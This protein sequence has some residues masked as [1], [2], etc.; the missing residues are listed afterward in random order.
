[1]S[2]VE[3][4][5]SDAEDVVGPAGSHGAPKCATKQRIDW[6][7]TISKTAAK[8]EIRA[9]VEMVDS[10]ATTK[11]RALVQTMLTHIKNSKNPEVLEHAFT[12][13]TAMLDTHGMLPPPRCIAPNKM[14]TIQLAWSSGGA[15]A[16]SYMVMEKLSICLFDQQYGPPSGA[17]RA[18]KLQSKRDA[19][20][21]EQRSRRGGRQRKLSAVASQAAAAAA[22]RKA[23][24]REKRLAKAGL[25]GAFK[26]SSE[27]PIVTLETFWT[28]Q[29][30]GKY[31]T[32]LRTMYARQKSL[33]ARTGG[34]NA[35]PASSDTQLPTELVSAASV[36]HWFFL[37]ENSE[38]ASKQPVAA[39]KIS[40]KRK[41]RESKKTGTKTRIS[42]MS[43][44]A[45][46]RPKK[47]QKTRK[48]SA[49]TRQKRK[50][51]K[52]LAK[53]KAKAEAKAKKAKVKEAK[54]AKKAMARKARKA[55][56]AKAKEAKMARKAKKKVT[57]SKNLLNKS[58]VEK[59]TTLSNRAKSRIKGQAKLDA[60]E[61]HRQEIEAANR[62]FELSRKLE[63]DNLEAE[64]SK[65][66][67]QRAANAQAIV[68]EFGPAI[69]V[70]MEEVVALVDYY[71]IHSSRIDF[72]CEWKQKR[73]N[74]K[75]AKKSEKG[76]AAA[77]AAVSS[78][79]VVAAPKTSL[80]RWEKLLMS[81]ERNAR[82]LPIQ[83]ADLFSQRVV[84]FIRD[85]WV[86]VEKK[87][88]RGRKK[89]K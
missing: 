56:K 46:R 47:R 80:M 59:P 52:K 16:I 22:K 74:P 70:L 31:G 79:S 19:A 57:K 66:K 42:K 88:W 54:K 14:S 27:M 38:I 78:V 61:T 76:E 3:D 83:N 24:A 84:Q 40:Q 28:Q 53:A 72:E 5:D 45:S 9:D 48:E 39:L 89:R 51:E 21:A 29:V 37:D 33:F 10:E 17:K 68:K 77:G 32:L 35:K 82:S 4:D 34:G 13:L 86:R 60:A 2:D 25:Q 50:L 73:G 58:K 49:S 20:K 62:A 55:E 41:K 65:Q 26:F 71:R 43:K 11:K 23:A 8:E 75:S 6:T 15:R 85:S 1:M 81:V 64:W 30:A 67:A 36:A 18:E 63:K 7:G 12:A 44:K 69:S 87:D